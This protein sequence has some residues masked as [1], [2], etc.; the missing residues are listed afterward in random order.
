MCWAPF[1]DYSLNISQWYG[2]EHANVLNPKA[3]FRESDSRIPKPY[4]KHVFY[5]NQHDAIAT[6]VEGKKWKFADIRPDAIVS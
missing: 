6:L 3:P 2:F 1:M 5:Y 4:A